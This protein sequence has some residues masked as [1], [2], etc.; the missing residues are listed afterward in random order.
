MGQWPLGRTN[1]QQMVDIYT[2]I[3]YTVNSTYTRRLQRD[4]GF[5]KD[6]GFSFY[7]SQLFLR[8][9]VKDK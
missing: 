8:N 1:I 9:N 7:L 2:N 5:V 3:Q 6:N 4:A